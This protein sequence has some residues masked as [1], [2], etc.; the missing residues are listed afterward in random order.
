MQRCCEKATS[1]GG[2]VQIP[3]HSPVL[4]E[5][6]HSAFFSTTMLRNTRVIAKRFQSSGFKNTYNF[7]TNPPPVHEYWNLRNSSVLLAFIPLYFGVGYIA[8]STGSELSGFEAL[9][10]AADSDIVKGLGFGEPQKK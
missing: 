5:S 6:N 4:R 7:N 10:A 8:K 3:A 2:A 9:K 1:G